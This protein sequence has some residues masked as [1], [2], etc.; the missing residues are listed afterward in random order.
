M[1]VLLRFLA[2]DKADVI[3]DVGAGTGVIADEISKYCDEVFALDPDAKRVEYIKKKYPQV[4]AFDG[5]AEAIQFPENYF[6]KVFA[7]SSF[8]HFRDKDSALYEIHRVLKKDGR[9]VIRDAGPAGRRSSFESRAANV[10]FTPLEEL[11][12]KLEH[13]EFEI[14]D[15]QKSDGYYFVSARKI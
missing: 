13:A 11:K 9:L 14:I 7:V 4:K 1:P 8:H 10:Q 12:E 2:P 5:S 15:S 6:T 3:L